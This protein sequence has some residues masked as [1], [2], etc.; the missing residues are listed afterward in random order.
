MTAPVTEEI[1]YLA[2]VLKSSNLDKERSIIL[3]TDLLLTVTYNNIPSAEYK[4]VGLTIG[5]F[6]QSVRNNR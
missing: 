3:L 6:I 1:D 2:S 5:A 4:N